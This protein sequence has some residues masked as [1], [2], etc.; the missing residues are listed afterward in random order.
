METKI[1]KAGLGRGLSSLFEKAPALT[2]E[3]ESLLKSSSS[4]SVSE[5]QETLKEV[6]RTV[7]LTQIRPS[8]F[9]PRQYFEEEALEALAQSI[10][11]HG[12]LQPLVVREKHK[13]SLEGGPVIYEIVAGERR[14][15]A[16]QKAGLAF[17]P[18][19]VQPFLDQE[20]LRIALIENIQREDLTPIEEAEGYKRLLQEGG[21]T[22]EE[23][24]NLLGKSRSH[25]ANMLRL[26]G[27]P[28]RVKEMVN[29]GILTTGHVRALL[30]VDNV[31]HLAEQILS[32]QLSVRETEA[33]I[34][35][36]K[37]RPARSPQTL[38]QASSSKP[39][40][41][42]KKEEISEKIL[43]PSSSQNPEMMALESHLSEIF[44]VKNN[45][46]LNE[47]GGGF[48]VLHFETYEEL[49][50]LFN[51]LTGLEKNMI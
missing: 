34:Q 33:L 14:W 6:L 51:K 32:K 46:H 26:N 38:S 15:R 24:A 31:E 41:I 39:A 42:P 25:I 4:S 47:N 44:G 43:N 2:G 16:A 7:S 36:I 40:H 27:L 35:K 12:V 21:Y 11:T 17:V 23:L 22:Q 9:Q 18:V 28:E 45:I 30:T 37:G 5:G 50:G 48:L 10:R 49:D 8:S 13:G 29:K 3:G 1:K 19:I 20:A